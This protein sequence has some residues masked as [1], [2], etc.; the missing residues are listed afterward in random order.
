MK[1]LLKNR[2]NK[3]V[4]EGVIAMKN[5]EI[6]EK[7]SRDSGRGSDPGVRLRVRVRVDRADELDLRFQLLSSSILF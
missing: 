2:S 5:I 7:A 6:E 4:F 3:G 1:W